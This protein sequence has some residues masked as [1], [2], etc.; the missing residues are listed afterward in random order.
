MS[1]GTAKNSVDALNQSAAKMK[2]KHILQAVRDWN[3]V[4]AFFHQRYGIQMKCIE[5]NCLSA[6]KDE[7]LGYVKIRRPVEM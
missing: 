6:K 1:H 5:V 2:H 4:C 3:V 7:D